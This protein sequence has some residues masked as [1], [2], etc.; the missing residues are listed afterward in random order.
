V[1]PAAE[2]G[3]VPVVLVH[4]APDR[5]KNLRPVIEQLGD[6][7][8]TVYDRRGYGKS[9]AAGQGDDG[10][11][12][13]GFGVH[14]ADLIEILEGRQSVVVAQ[15]A[16]GTIA[17][18]AA[19]ERPDL[20]AALGVWE[21][22]LVGWDWW[23]ADVAWERTMALAAYKDPRQLG[24]DFNRSIV[25]DDRWD[26][27]QPAT[28]ELLR[29]EGAAFQADLASQGSPLFD[30][31]DLKV[32]LIVGM[33]TI[34]PDPNYLQSHRDLAALTG[35]GLYVAE[36]VDHFAHITRPEAWVELVRRTVALVASD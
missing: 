31:D 23:Y 8:V 5:S 17:M 15:S 19:V 1:R 3:G 22:P 9:V 25:G 34:A 7:A 36:G 33:G 32:P 27:L 11:I 14:A 6:L 26:A 12:I 29:S 16:G 35:A 24:E 10:K 2:A 30:L 13:G 4:G 18:Q 28:R 21:P 20:F